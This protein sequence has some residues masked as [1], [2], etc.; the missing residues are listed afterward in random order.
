[1]KKQKMSVLITKNTIVLGFAD[2][3]FQIENGTAT[4]EAVLKAIKAGKSPA[5]VRRLADPKERVRRWSCGGFTV[6]GND[7]RWT[8]KPSYK[9]PECLTTAL[10]EFVDNKWPAEAFCAFLRRLLKNPS[11]RSVE[12]F[13]KFIVTQGLTIDQEGYVIA[14]KSVR[15]S[16]ND[17]YTNS[18]S[19]K[20]GCHNKMDRNLVCDDPNN[21]CAPGFHI[22][23]REF[24]LSFGGST[25]H[26]MA[27]KVDPQ[28]LVC[29]PYDCGF[30]KC[31]I[32][33]YTV[34]QEIGREK[35]LTSFYGAEPKAAP[36]PK[37]AKKV[38]K[39][40]VVECQGC[41]SKI[42]VTVAYCPVCGEAQ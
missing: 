42:S 10:L 13:Y 3:P 30:A 33:E 14:L 18:I 39:Q 1:M 15:D 16:Y 22:G 24:V 11:N 21:G 36:A 9:I 25:G 4:A 32:C 38:K 2:G 23:G 26:V 17:H 12:T 40:K 19:N 7:V 8:E 28:N 34:V 29:V 35:K 31:R 41:G 27:V 37:K 20:V 5:V 6:V